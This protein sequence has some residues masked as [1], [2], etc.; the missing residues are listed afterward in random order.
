MRYI[1][2]LLESELDKAAHQFPA[3][4]VTGPRRS[5]KTTMLRRLFPAAAYRLVEDPDVVARVQTDP[6]GFLDEL[7]PPVILDE[8]QNVPLIMNY[9]RTR[10]DAAQRRTGQWI[11]TGSQDAPL[12]QAVRESPAGRA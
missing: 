3:L 10:I 2:R 4:I 5:G 12:M 11:L 7:R 1:P 9:V 6:R 8:I